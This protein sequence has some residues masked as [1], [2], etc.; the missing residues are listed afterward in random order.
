MAWLTW[1]MVTAADGP[2]A[3]AISWQ[4]RASKEKTGGR[5]M[6]MHPDVQAALGP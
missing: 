6:P 5:T 4:H 1:A 3:D 2:I